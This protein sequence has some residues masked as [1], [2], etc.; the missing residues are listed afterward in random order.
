MSPNRHCLYARPCRWLAQFLQARSAIFRVHLR[1]NPSWWP[2]SFGVSGLPPPIP[3]REQMTG[4]SFGESHSS[5]YG[6]LK[7]KP[8]CPALAGYLVDDDELRS[9]QEMAIAWVI[10]LD[11]SAEGIY[12]E[13][14]EASC[15]VRANAMNCRSLHI[16]QPVPSAPTVPA[17][18]LF[19]LN[20]PLLTQ[21]AI[22][23]QPYVIAGCEQKPRSRSRSPVAQ[24]FGSRSWSYPNNM[25]IGG[26]RPG[27]SGP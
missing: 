18:P 22:P 8:C 4:R 24:H 25:P 26:T 6:L 14:S 12:W 21:A 10:D 27:R 9:P 2:V 11:P 19:L 3:Y 7:A 15:R 13:G 23:V 20:S 5:R 16:G 17:K 1:L